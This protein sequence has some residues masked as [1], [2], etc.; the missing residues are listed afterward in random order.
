MKFP[1]LRIMIGI[2]L[3]F[4]MSCEVL[5]DEQDDLQTPKEFGSD[6]A[7]LVEADEAGMPWP[8]REATI[9]LLE[10]ALRQEIY[11]GA[12]YAGAAQR[13]E[14]EDE[15]AIAMLFRQAATAE[16]IYTQNHLD[17]LHKMGVKVEMA[18]PDV[19]IRTTAENLEQAIGQE[20]LELKT[21]LPDSL[22]DINWPDSR[23]ALLS[24]EFARRASGK[25][26]RMF[27]KAL[28]Y[29]KQKENPAPIPPVSFNEKINAPK[30]KIKKHSIYHLKF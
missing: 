26:E 18:I 14:E 5:V 8:Q 28:Y 6:N 20:A 21:T 4:S 2:G 27:R 17:V 13:A 1:I 10:H 22:L 7:A 29:L 16:G 23:L 30:S 25:H 24:L 9:E 11:T 12:F 3:F 19:V 15:A